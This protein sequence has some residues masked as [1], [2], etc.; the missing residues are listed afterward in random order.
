[1]R[2]KSRRY[3][4]Y[5]LLRLAAGLVQLLPANAAYV[6]GRF[7]GCLGFQFL[8]KYR[9][10]AIQ[11]LKM[12]FGT[13]KGEGEI[14]RIARNVFMN[15]TGNFASMPHLTRVNKNNIDSIVRGHNMNRLDEV[16]SRGKGIIVLTAHF[17][18]WELVGAYMRIK[19]Y[20]GATIVRKLYFYKYDEYL[21]K[22]RRIHDVGTV[23]RDESPKKMLRYLKDNKVL[24][25]LADQDIPSIDGV[26]VDFF[27]KLAYTPKAPV[28]IAMASGAP[29][30][31]CFMIRNGLKYD[32]FVDEPIYAEAGRNKE[33]SVKH[34]TQ[35]WT[36]VLESYIRKYPDQWVWMHKRWRT[37]PA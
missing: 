19:G 30:V 13:V 3:Y 18:N 5:Y 34:Y 4:L 2:I 31:P 36:N 33:E 26:F 8:P 32:Y 12:A 22:L 28:K 20:E 6:I 10:P 24:G 9:K 15:I 11:H 17:G 16:L 27:G 14:N 7:C 21:A 29:I 25:M 35:K 37:Q 1:M 23:Y